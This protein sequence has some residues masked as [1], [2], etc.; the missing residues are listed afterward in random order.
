MTPAEA[1]VAIPVLNSLAV[2]LALPHVRVAG[3][4]KAGET[5]LVVFSAERPDFVSKDAGEIREYLREWSET[6]GSV[7][8]PVPG[9]GGQDL[10]LELITASDR[11]IDTGRRLRSDP[12]NHELALAGLSSV[13]AR[14]A[15]FE[16][17]SVK[18][19]E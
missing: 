6:L 10:T 8:A 13:M 19:A 18:E 17:S 4:D 2:T 1:S 11:V 14:I 7:I 5:T 12:G 3:F 15:A 9:D 16:Q